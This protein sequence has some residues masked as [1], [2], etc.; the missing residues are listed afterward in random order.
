MFVNEHIQSDLEPDIKQEISSF[1]T[2][3]ILQPS[4]T[5]F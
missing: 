1:K 5:Q 2:G 4:I 3:E